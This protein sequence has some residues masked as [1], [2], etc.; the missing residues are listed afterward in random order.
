MALKREHL[1]AAAVSLRPQSVP[2]LSENVVQATN[3]KRR[4]S[5]NAARKTFLPKLGGNA[6]KVWP[7]RLPQW[8]HGKGL[9]LYSM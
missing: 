9:T 6:A 3:M 8:K 7:A 5:V 4:H 2:R 1:T